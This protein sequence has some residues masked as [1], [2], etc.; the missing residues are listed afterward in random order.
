MELIDVVVIE[1]M[2]VVVVVELM[3]IVIVFGLMD[4]AA[5]IVGVALLPSA[6]VVGL[7]FIPGVVEALPVTEIEASCVVAVVE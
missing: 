6:E 1:F 4:D 5:A 3:D 2:D 7:L